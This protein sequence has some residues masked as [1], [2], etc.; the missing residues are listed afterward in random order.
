MI[1]MIDMFVFDTLKNNGYDI[2]LY[3]F[4]MI[5]SEA[6]EERYK[7]TDR[8]NTKILKELGLSLNN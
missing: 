4:N 3:K 6:K 8:I 1:V 5:L 2:D 7:E